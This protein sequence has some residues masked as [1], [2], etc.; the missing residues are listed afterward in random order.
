MTLNPFLSS[1][2]DGYQIGRVLRVEFAACLV[3]VAG[4]ERWADC[5]TGQR[6]RPGQMVTLSGSRIICLGPN[7]AGM[8]RAE[9]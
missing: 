7:L 6:Y 3:S 5:G 2:R 8:T 9:V 1:G 4:Q